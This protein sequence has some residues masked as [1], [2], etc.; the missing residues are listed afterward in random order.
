[1]DRRKK[2]LLKKLFQQ[3][4]LTPVKTEGKPGPLDRRKYVR[5]TSKDRRHS[6]RKQA[7]Y[8]NPKM[9]Y[10]EAHAEAIEPVEFWDDWMD[11]RDSFRDKSTEGT[12][13]IKK[14]IAIRKARK[15]KHG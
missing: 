15:H 9:K 10:K 11:F 6:G 4:V 1:M 5:P 13:D 8:V 7:R 14:Q 12:E 2:K 3:M